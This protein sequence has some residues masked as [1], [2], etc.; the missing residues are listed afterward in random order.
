MGPKRVSQF[1]LNLHQV[2]LE[3]PEPHQFVPPLSHAAAR[4]GTLTQTND[5]LDTIG[6]ENSLHRHLPPQKSDPQSLIQINHLQSRR[7]GPAMRDVMKQLHWPRPWK[8]P[9]GIFP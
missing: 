4:G 6:K 7:E 5:M 9:A 1:G 2:A 3:V 8:Q